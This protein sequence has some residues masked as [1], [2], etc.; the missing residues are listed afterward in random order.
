MILA[1][2]LRHISLRH[3]RYQKMQTLLSVLGI[4]IG[5]AAIVSVGIV[6]ENIVRS[7]ENT[8]NYTMGRALLQVSGPAT[9]FPEDIVNRVS[10][11]PGV[12]YAVPAIEVTATLLGSQERTIMVLGVDMLQDQHIRDYRLS[13]ESADIPDPLMFLARADSILLTK[14]LADQEGIGIERQVKL[15]TIEGIIPFRVRGLLGSEGPAKAMAGNMAVMDLFAA[16]KAFGKEGKIDRID[17]SILRDADVAAVKKGIQE[18]LPE[19]YKVETAAGRTKQIN[20]MLMRFQKSL[21]FMRF[22]II[23]V[24]MYIIY[25]SVS[26]AVVR[27]KREIGIVRALGATRR[28]VVL[29]F[30]GETILNGALGSAAGAGLGIVQA[31]MSID[32]VTKIVSEAFLNTS[33]AGIN[34]SGSHLITGLVSGLLASLIAALLPS[35]SSIRI[36]PISAIRSLPFSEE[37]FLKKK[38]A[39]LSS[40]LLFLSALLLVLYKTVPPS[41]HF[42]G[43]LVVFFATLCLLGGTSLAT[44]H[45]LKGFLHIFHRS[46]R[47]LG[48]AGRLAGLN[49]RK[50]IIRNAVA[51]SAVFFGIAMYV[52]SAG[53]TGSI[54]GSIMTYMDKNVRADI[55]VTAGRPL[56]TATQSE[57][58]PYRVLGEIDGIP[59]VLSTD[60]FRR[61]YIDYQDSRILLMAMDMPK[62]LAYSDLTFIEGDRNVLLRRCPGQNSI[63]INE[64]FSQKHGVRTG[65]SV[66]L[67]TPRGTVDFTVV[68]V[69]EEESSDAGSA[70][71]D[72]TTLQ[73]L[74]GDTL[75]DIISVRT[76]SKDAVPGV[77]AAIENKLGPRRKIF[78]LPLHEWRNELLN[79]LNEMFVFNHALSF[80][81]LIIACF[82]IVVTLFSSVLERVR[83]IGI[84]RSIG[85]LRSQVFRIVLIES[86]LL[87]FVGGLLGCIGGVII[88]WAIFEA[89]WRADFGRSIAYLVPYRSLIPALLLS[90]GLSSLS[91]LYPAWR[92]AR[93]NITEALAYE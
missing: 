2:L 76:T 12:E 30:L 86:M 73:R 81:T 93:T 14:E 5:V 18:A 40:A 4:A 20:T 17:I 80:L 39:V 88:G 77:I 58:M 62:R 48:P 64:G 66:R 7:F 68:A 33:V 61:V 47:V 15:R 37:V 28:Q 53:F 23:F 71:V 6:N 27:R 56:T 44:P 69:V 83:E 26:F 84:L 65:D 63:A 9:G 25:N 11:V 10:E 51:S 85:M 16:Q 55:I 36:T 13:E 87:G 52:S 54:Q 35:F 82:G 72:I 92:A 32:A 75:V 24:A 31:R 41:S 43:M 34:I 57:P 29:L 46:L 1:N 59:G 50:N 8:I 21:D 38:L 45:F 67:P 3:L 78:A 74:W 19:G 90:V 60:A 91:G 49:L 89:F 42:H 22:V 70:F 79:L